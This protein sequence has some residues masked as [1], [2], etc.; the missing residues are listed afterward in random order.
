MASGR[1]LDYVAQGLA[2]SR[3]VAATLAADVLSGAL[4]LYYAYDTGVL[5]VLDT[6]APAWVEYPSAPV[7]AAD[8]VFTPAG[9]IAATD[10]QAAL[11]ELDTEKATITY[12]DAKVA[13]LSWKQA[14][15]VA[16]TSALTLATDFENGDTIDGVVLATGDRVLIKNQASGVE[17]GIY[18]VNA[19]GAPTRATDAD[20]GAELVNASVYVSEGT[21]LADTQWTCTTNATITVGV[22]S[23]AFAQFVAGGYTDENARDAIGTALTAGNGIDI[24]VNDGADTITI[25]VD[26]SE[27]EATDSEMWT[28]TSTTKAVTPNKIFD[29]AVAQTLTDGATVTPDFNTGL[30]FEWTIGGNRT[31]AN[32]TNTKNGQSGTIRITQ[33]GTGTRVITYGA[34]WRFPGGAAASGVLSTGA[35]DTDLLSYIVGSDGNIYATLGKDFAA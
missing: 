29:A 30:N 3:P 35:G 15:R 19:S 28:G 9:G 31:L 8:V 21:T 18:T 27:V 25:D 26:V 2:A 4:A 17:N 10:V 13:G 24:T 14:V 11:E 33:D 34:N 32:P 22:T 20:S 5:S 7:D 1:F 6:D 16:T 23:L 12:V